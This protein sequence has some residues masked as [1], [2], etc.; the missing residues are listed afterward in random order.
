MSIRKRDNPTRSRHHR[1]ALEPRQLF[2]GAAVVEAASHADNPLDAQHHD[3]APDA[4]KAVF[5]PPAPVPAPASIAAPAPA[6]AIPAHEVYVVDSHVQNWQSLVSQLPEGSRVLVL[7]AQH[8]GLEQINDAL[9]N[10]NNITA[11]HIISHGASDE[12]TL[13]SDKLNDQTI[14]QYQQQLETLGEKLTADGDILLYGCDVTSKD[15]IFINRMADY[16]H[17]DVAAS[18]DETGSAAKAADWTLESHTGTI[19]TRSLELAYD[20]VLQAPELTA[21]V[22]D[23]VVS[24]PSTLHPGGETSGFGLTLNA[25]DENVVI[26]VTLSNDAAGDLVNGGQTAKS[27]EFVGSVADAQA[28]LNALKFTASNTEL[29]NQSASTDVQFYV[30]TL[31]GSDSLVTHITVTP[32]ND[33][34]TVADSTLSVPENNGSGTVITETT[35]AAIDPE[36]QIGAQSAS[37]IVYSLTAMPQYGYL[38]LNGTRL[39]VGS[40]FTQQDVRD[41]KLVYIHTATGS[42]QNTADGF[43]AKVNDGATPIDQSDN[44]TV[45]LDIIPEN[46]L[47][48]IQGGGI[49]YEGQPENAVNT[50]N[51]GQYIVATSGGDT[52]DT[53][54]TLTITSLPTHGTLYFDGVPVQ[55]GQQIAYADRSRLNYANDG[56]DGISQDTFGVRVTDQGGGTGTPASS[57]AVITL[58]IQPVDDDPF[59]DANSS[60]HA[61]VAPGPDDVII[62]PEMLAGLDTDSPA[63]RVSFVVD[64]A[65]LTHGYLTLNGL[66]LETG[67]TFTMEDVVEGK[68]AY[69]QYLNAQPGGIDVFNFRVIDHS[70]ALRWNPDGSTFTRQGGIYDGGAA[71][72]QLTHF[73]FTIGLV[74]LAN[75]PTPDQVAPWEVPDITDNS[76]YIGTDVTNPALPPHGAINEGGS[77]VLSGTGNIKDSTPGMSYVVQGISPDQIVYTYLGTDAGQSGLTILKSDGHGGTTTVNAFGTFTQADLDAGLVRIVHDGGENFVFNAHFSVSAGQVTLDARG[78]P[79]A[80]TWNPDL[81]IFVTPVNDAPVISGSSNTVLAEGE[82]V[83]ITTSQLQLSD[84]DDANSGS[85]WETLTQINGSNNYALNNETSGANALKIVFQ[86]LPTGGVLQYFNGTSWVTITSADIGTLKLDAS[87][88]KSDNSSGLRFV[89]NG[90]EVRST[91]FIVSAVDRWGGD[92]C[93]Q[94]D[95]GYYHHQR[96]RWAENSGNAGQPGYRRAARF[97]KPGGRVSGQ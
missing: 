42:T 64:T 72:D 43:S 31:S 86:S 12:I 19:E 1:F 75:N 26:S 11:I 73:Q 88:L 91:D 67:N 46:Q 51:V 6:D 97:T 74:R 10:D 83:Y 40:V 63:E 79:V 52:Q 89:S 36:L 54:L 16:T 17:A 27:L 80:V 60:L 3:N 4:S 57:D 70:T 69:V 29:G 23:M 61:E 76:G 45:T 85:P 65:G 21:S 68:V 2:D 18:N 5:V 14:G 15:T 37:Q 59:L 62:I 49:V 44:V 30:L 66:R 93:C 87:L 95:R 24:E 22:P 32:A 47:P 55:V 81:K 7:D 96:E 77:L 41:G 8:S 56:Q 82:T 53:N 13:G 58:D 38:T 50:G 34:V 94:C 84:P 9:K 33:P 78:N 35:L 71:S 92:V 25:S 39:G 90:S 28:W 48:T 20:G